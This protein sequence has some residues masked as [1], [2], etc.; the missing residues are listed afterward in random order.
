MGA[1]RQVKNTKFPPSLLRVDN[2]GGIIKNIYIEPTISIPSSYELLTAGFAKK[3]AL[4][5]H[6]ARFQ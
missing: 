1:M 4:N 2:S 6:T 5:G 3:R